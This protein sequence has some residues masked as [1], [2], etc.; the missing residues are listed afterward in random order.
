MGASKVVLPG[1]GMARGSMKEYAEAVRL[2]KGEG[3][4]LGHPPMPWS[5]VYQG[6][7]MAQQLAAGERVRLRLEAWGSLGEA[8]AHQDGREIRVFGGIPGELVVAEVV[9][10]RRDYVA[11]RAVEILEPSPD[12]VTPRCPYFGP[13]TGCQ[14][15]HLAYSRQLEV[16]RQ[17]VVE[18]L[19]D[20]GGSGAPP[21]LPTL[22]SPDQLGYRNHARFT[23]GRKWGEVGFVNR[24]SRRFVPIQSCMLMH[25]WMNQAL[26]QLQRK[27]A[28]TSQLSIR[29]GFRTGDF[30]VQPRLKSDDIPLA[31]GQTHYREVLGG[32]EFR[33][34]SSSF[35][36]VNPAQAEVV[37]DL[38]KRGLRLSGTGLLVDA[39]AGVGTFAALLA[40]FAARTVAIEESA[41]AV[42]DARANA[43]GLDDIQFLQGKV[44]DVLPQIEE[45]PL[46]LV[47]D[48]PRA[49][50][51]PA[52]LE[53]V[54]RAAPERL[55]YVSCDP[56]T[57]ARDL[58]VLCQ[59]PFI[60][61]EVQ[62]VDM[63]PQTHHV[64][65]VATLYHKDSATAS[66]VLPLTGAHTAPQG[67][68]LI[69]ASTSPRRRDLLE[70]MGLDFSVEPPWADEEMHDGE[71]PEELVE[72]L[73]LDKASSVA[74]SRCR[75]LIVG[76]DSVVV[77]D[78][79]VLGKPSDKTE[80]RDMLRRLRGR[81]HHV[82]TGVAVV[83]PALGT[84]QASSV[85]SR[86]HMR[87]YSDREIDAYVASG[88]PMDKAGAYAIQDPGFHPAES[89]EG[90]Y[91]NVMGLPV[92]TVAEMLEA[93]GMP[94]ATGDVRVPHGCT[95][96]PF[97]PAARASSAGASPSGASLAGTSTEG[98]QA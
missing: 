57:L 20:L 91:P 19:K 93:A 77:L 35:F 23:V 27:S 88:E 26:A 83:D 70:C 32:R 58:E 92:C 16:K 69:L 21:V 24:D 8:V 90:C 44:E 13:C 82:M 71:S 52:A 25:P 49:G 56:D 41:S 95:S 62:P 61:E 87:H 55:V 60:L 40:P 72:R 76:A 50:C 98:A 4:R 39:Y 3:S 64:E 36:Q 31:S 1:G 38:I 74:H 28:E 34:A 48:P 18:A 17:R 96:C 81:E 47:L 78:G 29:Y 15:Q 10:D 68:G 54:I 63:F 11:A 42:L 86:V 66:A 43:A 37:V 14:W 6:S 79:Q 85:R 94:I 59:G 2:P 65:C 5:I 33:I 30:L 97:S 53:A 80:A 89:M 45:R 67:N 9:R 46:A 51:H 73:A 75:G 22:P 84:R 7:A 12:R